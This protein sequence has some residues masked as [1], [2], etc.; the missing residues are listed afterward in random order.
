ME[1]GGEEQL[2]G[3]TR[4]EGGEKEERNDSVLMHRAGA[5]A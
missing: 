1:V 5:C 4:D 3:G 2:M